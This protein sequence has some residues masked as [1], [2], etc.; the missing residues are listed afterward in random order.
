MRFVST[1][2]RGAFIVELERR[3]DSR[4]FFARAFCQRE[5]TEHGLNPEVAQCNI[6]F[7]ERRGTLRGMHY[8][9]KPHEEA[10]L[11]RCTRGGIFDVIVDLRTESETRLRWFGVE[12]SAE[13][14][15]ALYVP[16]GLAHGYQTLQDGSE[17]FYQVSEEYTPMAERGV[18]WNDPAFG[19][20][21][22]IADPILSAKDAAYANYEVSKPSPGS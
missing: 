10:K 22:P 15:R 13:N 7:N 16:E 3:E 18:R 4:G 2:I 20:R 17:I 11:V 21:W 1:P 19:I 8:Q 14:R 9:A 12:L 5:F 6:S